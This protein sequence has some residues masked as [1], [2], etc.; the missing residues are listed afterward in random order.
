MTTARD[1][2]KSALRKIAVLGAGSSL[3]NEEAQD[4]LDLLNGILSEWS[5]AGGLIFNETSET[6]NLTG[7]ISYT[8]GSGGDFNTS[9]PTQIT[10]LFTSSGGIDYI[11]HEYSSAQYASL[12]YK[13]AEGYPD[14]YYYDNNYPLGTIYLY[15]KPTGVSTITINS[16]KELTSFTTLDAAFSMPAEYRI[17]LEHNLAVYIAPEYEK[18][19]SITIQRVAKRTKNAIL[20]QNN[21]NRRNIATLDVPCSTRGVFNIYTGR[22]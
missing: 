10:S 16:V 9:R 7:A 19:A 5:A 17:A 20:T 13:N 18:E 3:S 2:I 4:G 15:P 14:I 1:I 6:F 8:V 12:A 11:A 21:H 22:E